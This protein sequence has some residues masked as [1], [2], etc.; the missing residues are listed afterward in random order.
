MVPSATFTRWGPPVLFP[1][2]PASKV[3]PKPER[4]EDLTHQVLV[5]D[6]E[7]RFE[8][9]KHFQGGRMAQ[10]GAHGL[11]FECD[12]IGWVFHREPQ[13]GATDQRLEDVLQQ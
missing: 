11:K 3:S 5:E 1:T 8:L 7:H 2:A 12:A 6:L 10:A 4:D 9:R 13:G